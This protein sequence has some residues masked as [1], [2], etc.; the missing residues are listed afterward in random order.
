MKENVTVK[1]Y[2]KINISL[3]IKSL[4][5]DGKHEVDMIMQSLPLHDVIEMKKFPSE[6]KEIV[7]KSNAAWVPTDSKNTAF[8]AAELLTKNFSKIDCGTEIFIDK[9]VPGCGG[10]GGSSADAAGVLLGMNELFDL[11]LS[12]EELQEYGAQIGADVPFLIRY[13]AA[14]ATG[15]GTTLEYV[16]PLKEGILLLVNSG[17]EVSTA[18][19]YKMYDEL[20]RCGKIPSE[21]HQ[22]AKETARAMKKGLDALV[23]KTKNVLEYPAFYLQHEIEKIKKEIAEFGAAV[24]MMSGSGATVF[25]IFRK[26]NKEKVIA[27]QKVF[28]K[29]GWFTYICDFENF[30]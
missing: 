11:G 17:A 12:I 29:R 30:E 14:I 10:L 22:E 21:A 27:A 20:E 3:N 19:A 15:T 2:C 16:E 26:E 1:A 8:K 18:E 25:G 6:K 28:E 7:L 23:G 13:G 9:K 4:R 24:S 5:E